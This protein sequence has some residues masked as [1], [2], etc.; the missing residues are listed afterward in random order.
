MFPSFPIL[1]ID[2]GTTVTKAVVWDASGPVST[3]RLALTTSHPA[4]GRAEQD[5]GSWWRSVLA[6]CATARAA[7]PAAFDAVGAIGF[8]GARQTFVPVAADGRP[9]GPGIVWSDRRAAAEAAELAAAAP[10]AE[11]MRPLRGITPEAAAGAEAVRQLTGIVLDA[12]AVPA[13]IRWLQA[14]EPDR[15]ASAR[16]LLSPRDLI[17]LRMTGSVTTD[18]TMA[19][20]TGLYD[21]TGDPVAEL[22]GPAADRLPE[23]V[24]SATVA[25]T[26]VPAA[27]GELELRA[28]IPVVIGAGDRQC[29]LVGA[30]ASSMRAMVSWGTTANASVPIAAWPRDI[31]AGALVTRGALAGWQL[32]CGVSA[33]GS[34]LAW[35]GELTGRDPDALLDGAA[36]CPP[37]ARGVLALPWLGGARAPWWRDRAGAAFL[38]LGPGHGPADLGRAAVESVAWEIDRCLEVL[39]PGRSVRSRRAGGGGVGPPPADG[40]AF[41]RPD[42]D[43]LALAGGSRLPLWVQILTAVTDLRATCRRSGEAASAGA[44]VIT[45]RAL[46]ADLDIGEFDP[47]MGE[48]HPLPELV[49]QYLLLRPAAEMAA[50]AVISLADQP[51]VSVTGP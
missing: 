2:L 15:L 16:W 31:P 12:A 44:A 20:A 48:A 14:H 1:T 19:S 3:G 8:S 6:A 43:G 38:G 13:K 39:A 46:G 11:A 49:E 23:P 18:S 9:L 42:L 50:R 28:G 47:V 22:V 27:A 10:G 30:G 35:L 37:G 5:P 24:A 34:L 40:G 45:A 25:G 51:R 4:G 36:S 17:V 32:E 7:A 29:E 21:R 41:E 33:A 26:L